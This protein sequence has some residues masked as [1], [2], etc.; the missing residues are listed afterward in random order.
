MSEL[1]KPRVDPLGLNYECD[2]ALIAESIAE[3]GSP[4]RARQPQARRKHGAIIGGDRLVWRTGS[5]GL[6]LHHG[7]ARKLL[8]RIVPDQT[9]PGMFRIE[10]PDGRI[11]DMVNLTRAKD[12]AIAIAL[13]S[14]NSK[15]QE[16]SRDAPSVRQK[17]L[18]VGGPTAEGNRIPSARTKRAK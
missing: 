10:F 17:S 15:A 4:D 11:S 5:D 3:L 18:P 9:W 2:S 14:L 8:A 13:R 7:Q 16:T 6:T 12:A 1:S